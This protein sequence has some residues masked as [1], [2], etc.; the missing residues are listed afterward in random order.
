LNVLQQICPKENISESLLAHL[1][2]LDM[3]MNQVILEIIIY[4]GEGVSIEIHN[5]LLWNGL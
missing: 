2:V 3:L 4:I 1:N 5:L